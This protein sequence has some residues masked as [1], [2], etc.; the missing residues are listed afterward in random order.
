MC[1]RLDGYLES[2]SWLFLPF[3]D[4]WSSDAQAAA[5]W[6]GRQALSAE[7]VELVEHAGIDGDSRCGIDLFESQAHAP[8]IDVLL[9][10]LTR[11]LVQGLVQAGRHRGSSHFS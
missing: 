10:E 9:F 3:R 11:E 7:I 8:P 5:L 1:R 6:N 4:D 2:R